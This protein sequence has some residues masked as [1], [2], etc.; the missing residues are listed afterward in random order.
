MAERANRIQAKQ[1]ATKLAN[2]SVP[3]KALMKASQKPR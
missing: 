3:V 1:P 2:Q